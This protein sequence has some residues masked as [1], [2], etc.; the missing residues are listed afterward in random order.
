M[1]VYLKCVTYTQPICMLL[2]LLNFAVLGLCVCY[3][4]RIYSISCLR[5]NLKKCS[6]FFVLTD[7]QMRY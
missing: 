2:N 7:M 4:H 1:L 5:M 3:I 6:A